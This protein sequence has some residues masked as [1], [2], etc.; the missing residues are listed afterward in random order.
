MDDNK[1]TLTPEDVARVKGLGFLRRKGPTNSTA[2]SL[3]VT[4]S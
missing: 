4:E 1:K 2:A 3:P